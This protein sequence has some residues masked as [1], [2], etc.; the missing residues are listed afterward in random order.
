MVKRIPHLTHVLA[1][2]I[3]RILRKKLK[4]LASGVLELQQDLD[5]EAREQH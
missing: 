3:R 5:S 4:A 1:P 2:Q